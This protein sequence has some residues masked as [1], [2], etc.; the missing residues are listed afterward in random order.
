MGKKRGISLYLAMLTMWPAIEASFCRRRHSL[1]KSTV[2]KAVMGKVA[3][4][5]EV[6]VLE[7]VADRPPAV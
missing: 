6:G 3:G 2:S 1:I 4:G 5:G 7:L